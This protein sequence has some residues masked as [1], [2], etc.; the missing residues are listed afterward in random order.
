MSAVAPQIFTDRLYLNNITEEDAEM[1]VELRS[2]PEVYKYF[3]NSIKI[4]VEEHLR[5]FSNSY[6]QDKNR[7]D[8]M[9]RKKKDGTQVG[10]FGLKRITDSTAEISYIL[11]SSNQGRGYAREAICA[12]MN[13][14]KNYEWKCNKVIATI[15]Q[16]N[17]RSIDFIKGMGYVFSEK[18]ES[19]VI[20]EKQL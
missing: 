3:I 16:S 18:Q 17:Q 11:S 10:I 15:H 1:I 7:I 19:F 9:A 20:Y 6:L 4:T 13:W 8:F 14:I 5:W 2:N 12:L